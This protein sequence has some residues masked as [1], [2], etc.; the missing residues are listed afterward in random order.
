MI[1]LCLEILISGVIM[2]SS[3]NNAIDHNSGVVYNYSGKSNYVLPDNYN[4]TLLCEKQMQ[5][6]ANTDN[7]DQKMFNYI[8]SI[9]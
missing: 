9:E 4:M 5:R 6:F 8:N 2:T 7:T 3:L 1:D